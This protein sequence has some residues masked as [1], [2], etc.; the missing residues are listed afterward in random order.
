MAIS[1]DEAERQIVQFGEAV[2]N[3]GKHVGN[4]QGEHLELRQQLC[5]TRGQAG[6]NKAR[7]EKSELRL[8]KAVCPEKLVPGKDISKTWSEDVERWAKAK[9]LQLQVILPTAAAQKETV[10]MPSDGIEDDI[11]FA[12]GHLKKLMGDKEYKG[13]VQNFRG[14]NALEAYR[15][16]H[17]R[18][19]PQTAVARSKHIR[20]C[21]NFGINHA[22]TKVP[23]VPNVITEFEK[24]CGDYHEDY[25]TYCLT[26][27]PLAR[28]S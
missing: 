22:N 21:T 16:L 8:M 20:L 2:A 5:E 6:F 24:V 4:L 17:R 7:H 14:D 3:F 15:M 9:E 18:Y 19:N 11:G 10:A 1:L 26:E 12:Y 13:I 25:G 27:K 28:T 23:D